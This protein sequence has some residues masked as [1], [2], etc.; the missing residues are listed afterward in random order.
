MPVY[1][2]N[3]ALHDALQRLALISMSDMQAMWIEVPLSPADKL[4][5]A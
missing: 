1:G 3:V 4:P 5:V 2:R